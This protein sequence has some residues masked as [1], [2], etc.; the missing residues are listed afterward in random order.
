M[1]AGSRPSRTPSTRRSRL[2]DQRRVDEP[3]SAPPGPPVP[4]SV[5]DLQRVIGDEAP[6]CCRRGRLPTSSWR[7]WAAARTRL[8]LSRRLSND[9]SVELL[10]C[11]LRVTVRHRASRRLH[12]RF[13]VL[14]SAHLCLQERDGQARL[15]RFLPASIAGVGPERMV[16]AYG[17]CLVYPSPTP[18][19]W[20]PS[21]VAHG[22]IVP[23]LSPHARSLEYAHGRARRSK[24]GTRHPGRN[25]SPS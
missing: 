17:T 3:F 8:A 10:G 1:T 13:G 23:P 7:A 15:P 9:P 22:G 14:H 18:R 11:R 20:M 25:P 2:G 12:L 16:G 4:P 5:R 19:P 24:P 21:S 6:S